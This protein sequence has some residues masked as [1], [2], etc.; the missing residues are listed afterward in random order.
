MCHKLSAYKKKEYELHN[1]IREISDELDRLEG[2]GKDT[3]EVFLQLEM[4]LEGFR[5]FRLAE[6]KKYGRSW[7]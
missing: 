5:V 2:E 4:A 3:A 1:K 7:K 6:V